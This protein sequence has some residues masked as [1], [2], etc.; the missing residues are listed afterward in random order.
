MSRPQQKGEIIDLSNRRKDAGS[1]RRKPRPKPRPKKRR[2][3]AR[4][5]NIT[6]ALFVIPFAFLAF[7]ATPRALLADM[8]VEGVVTRVVDGDTLYLSGV[9]TRIRLWGL[10]A[11]ERDDAGG[12]AATAKL[13]EIAEGR[14]LR[15]KQVDTDRYGRIVGQCFLSDG[16][17]ITAEMIRSGTATEYVKYS[18][19]YYAARNTFSNDQN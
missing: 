19:G 1:E 12:D 8:T 2:R 17:D 7:V 15:C 10:D 13:R 11:P 9:E 3:R 5:P 18:G 4:S 16:R 14:K 6:G